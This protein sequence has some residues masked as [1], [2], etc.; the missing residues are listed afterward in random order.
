MAGFSTTHGSQLAHANAVTPS[1]SDEGD[2]QELA[3]LVPFMV[4]D[5]C[6]RVEIAEQATYWQL[7]YYS[8]TSLAANE[9]Q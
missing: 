8:R 5:E 4:D 6:A 2:G 3:L 1:T 9:C 7:V